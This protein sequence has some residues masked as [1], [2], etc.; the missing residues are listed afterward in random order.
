VQQILNRLKQ[1]TLV[2]V[3]VKIGVVLNCFT[4][5]WC[6]KEICNLTRKLLI[7]KNWSF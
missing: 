4:P 5:E 1:K 2:H 6:S 3:I 7:Y